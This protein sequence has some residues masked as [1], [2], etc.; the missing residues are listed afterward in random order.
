[1]LQGALLGAAV[2]EVVWEAPR[3]SGSSGREVIDATVAR[4]NGQNIYLSDLRRPQMSKEGERLTLNEQL[5]KQVLLS[6]AVTLGLVPTDNEVQKQVES[7]KAQFKGFAGAGDLQLTA[8]EW[9]KERGMTFKDLSRF[10][11]EELATTNVKHFYSVDKPLIPHEDVQKYYHDHPVMTETMYT[12]KT[13]VL[14]EEQALAFDALSPRDIEWIEVDVAESKI[15][16]EMSFVHTQELGKASKPVKTAA[17]YQTVLVVAKVAPKRVPLTVRA[18]EIERI[19]T[20][21]YFKK[22]LDLFMD[23]LRKNSS[24]VIFKPI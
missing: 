8:D 13:A 9:L 19:L 11:R 4:V 20:E 22:T 17:G 7:F 24:L 1:M 12:I 14:S 15:S 16:E 18:P 6:R 23:D 10:Y 5:D 3:V 2:A 21:S